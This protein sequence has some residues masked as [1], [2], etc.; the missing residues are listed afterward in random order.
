MP[1]ERKPGIAGGLFWGTLSGFTSTICQAG[2]PPYQVYVMPMM[3]PK[4]VFVSTTAIFF[5]TLNVLK[6]APYLALGQFSTAGFGTSVALLPLA[7]A[8]N[9]L[10]F[11]L[12]RRTPQALFYKIVSVLLLLIS[13][14]LA[15]EGLMELFGR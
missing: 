12:I 1:R 9:Q 4:M 13:I 14:E 8:S 10:G 15:R 11:W 2:G 5:A 6:V 3:L 7:L